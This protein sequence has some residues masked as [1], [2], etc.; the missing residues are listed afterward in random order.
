MRLTATNGGGIAFSDF[1]FTTNQAP[2]AGALEVKNIRAG[3]KI[4]MSPN[5]TDT[6]V[7]LT[8][9]ITLSLGDGWDDEDDQPLNVRFGMQTSYSDNTTTTKWAQQTTNLQHVLYLPGGLF[10]FVFRKGLALPMPN[11]A[12]Q[13]TGYTAMVEVCD[14]LGAC[15]TASTSSFVVQRNDNTDTAVQNLISLININLNTGYRILLKLF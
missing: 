6:I 7:S 4:Q 13:R 15:S 12:C 5:T 8:T 1:T 9:P 3:S 10:P 11:A 14:S 2:T